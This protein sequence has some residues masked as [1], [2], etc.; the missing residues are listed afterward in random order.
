MAAPMPGLEPRD[1]T[2]SVAGD[3][4]TIHGRER[5]PHQNERTLLRAEWSVGPYAAEVTLSE[6]VNGAL[7]NATYGNGVL[8]VAMPKVP[9]GHAGVPADISLTAIE[10]TRGERV[11]HVSR[12]VQPTTTEEHLRQHARRTDEVKPI[13]TT[14]NGGAVQTGEGGNSR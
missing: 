14:G 6:P 12:T 3:R 11:G 8:V 10:A 1:I 13:R 5:G 2:I 9:R 4:L 7:T